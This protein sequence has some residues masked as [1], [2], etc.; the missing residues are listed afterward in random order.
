MLSTTACTIVAHVLATRPARVATIRSLRPCSSSA[1]VWRTAVNVFMN[2]T[3]SIMKAP[4]SVMKNEP[5]DAP[6][7]AP[8]TASSVGFVVSTWITP[9]RSSR[10]P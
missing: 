2:A 5:A 6:S 4:I 9:R 3:R 1:L 7:G 10:V 8:R